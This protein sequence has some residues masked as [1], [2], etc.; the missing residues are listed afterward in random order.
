MGFNIKINGKVAYLIFGMGLMPPILVLSFD[1]WWSSE[2]FF[3]YDLFI[4]TFWPQLVCPQLPLALLK[5]LFS[6]GKLMDNW[7]PGLLKKK[8]KLNTILLSIQ[9]AY[10]CY[11][12]YVI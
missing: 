7:K 11:F 12:S 6:N 3:F 10:F 8:E 9:T 4:F 2:T 5:T 1:E